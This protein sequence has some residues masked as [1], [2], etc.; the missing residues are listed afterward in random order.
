M[1]VAHCVH[2]NLIWIVARHCST[3]GKGCHIYIYIYGKNT[4]CSSL[5]CGTM[6]LLWKICRQL[7]FFC[8]YIYNFL[9][10]YWFLFYLYMHLLMLRDN[11]LFFDIIFK[12]IRTIFSLHFLY[13]IS[14]F[15]VLKT[16]MYY[17]LPVYKYNH[18]PVEIIIQHIQKYP[19]TPHPF[20]CIHEPVSPSTRSC[21]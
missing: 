13:Y 8:I 3:K 10:I 16:Y 12:K 1:S 11:I 7:Q 20:A 19:R 5:L 6:R 9:S 18:L 14:C 21:R 2:F 17:L 4:C 15:L